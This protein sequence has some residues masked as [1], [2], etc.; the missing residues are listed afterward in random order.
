MENLWLTDPEDHDFEWAA[1]YLEL[2]F[3]D[4][5]V[6]RII[7]DLKKTKT[8]NKKAKDILRASGLPL[9]PDDNI[10]V[11]KDI[12]KAKDG[13]RLSPILLIRDNEK[14]IIADWYH[15]MCAIYY[16]SEDLIIPCRLI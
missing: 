10:H 12:K 3:D 2:L 5:K 9:L 13:K 4:I 1:D 15:R 7:T 8:I 11:K 14:L 16:L 6:K